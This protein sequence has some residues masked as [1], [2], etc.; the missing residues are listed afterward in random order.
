MVIV[1]EI[2]DAS[3]G[4]AAVGSAPRLMVL[5]LLVRTGT[6][7]LPIGEL[8]KRTGIPASTLSHHLKSLAEG[9][10]ISQSKQG[11]TVINQAAYDRLRALGEYLLD[12]CCIEAEP[13]DIK[14]NQ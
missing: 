5:R 8:Q 1:M 2:E 13:A 11:T 12:E 7:G 3:I 6:E 9:G 14:E 4:F 10:L